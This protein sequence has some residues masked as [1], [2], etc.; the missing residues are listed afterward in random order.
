[1]QNTVMHML[2]VIPVIQYYN[3][4][5]YIILLLQYFQLQYFQSSCGLADVICRLYPS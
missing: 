3:T 2:L 4:I 1:M 5:L